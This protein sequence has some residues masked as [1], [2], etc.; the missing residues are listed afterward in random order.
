MAVNISERV[1]NN[2]PLTEAKLA[3]DADV[4]YADLKKAAIDDAKREV[5]GTS[6]VP[7][8]SDIPDIVAAWIGDKAT[9]ML[10]P[11]AKEWYAINY[12]RSQ[13]ND[14]GDNVDRYD[15]MRV[16]DGLKTELQRDCDENWSEVQELVGKNAAQVAVPTVSHDGTIINPTARAVNRGWF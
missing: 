12:Y 16:L 1:T 2:W 5:Y 4:G 11:V 6:T 13:S 8:E 9:I 10:I 14:R 3:A 15:I 7:S